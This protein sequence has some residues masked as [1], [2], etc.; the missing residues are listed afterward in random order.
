M[1]RGKQTLYIF[2]YVSTA[3]GNQPLTPVVH[4]GRA[5]PGVRRLRWRHGETFAKVTPH[6][7]RAD[8]GKCI[9]DSHHYVVSCYQPS[10]NR[11]I[12][13]TYCQA[14]IQKSSNSA[15]GRFVA[16]A[17]R[18]TT[19]SLRDVSSAYTLLPMEHHESPGIATAQVCILCKIQQSSV[20]RTSR[21]PATGSNPTQPLVRNWHIAEHRALRSVYSKTS[22]ERVANWMTGQ[23]L[24]TLCRRT[25]QHES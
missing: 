12:S 16:H 9:T 14:H 23:D 2:D 19:R 21:P 20:F 3:F 24:L 5:F 22:V 4:V 13:Y 17:I 10:R 7:S 8:K 18:R 25:S 11:F 1:T 15:V 6:R